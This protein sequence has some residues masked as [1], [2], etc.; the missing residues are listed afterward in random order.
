MSGET[1]IEMLNN[2]DVGSVQFYQRL[3]KMRAFNLDEK[4][5]ILEEDQRRFRDEIMRN[6]EHIKILEREIK[7]WEERVL[8]L[9]ACLAAAENGYIDDGGIR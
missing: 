8:V 2:R 1:T 4:S 9:R 3:F 7:T 5:K 6:Q